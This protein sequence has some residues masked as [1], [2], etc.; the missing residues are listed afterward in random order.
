VDWER[1]D[2]LLQAVADEA[3]HVLFCSSDLFATC[4]NLA[5]ALHEAVRQQIIIF[6]RANA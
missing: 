2:A 6:P 1:S 5:Q 3:R 4:G